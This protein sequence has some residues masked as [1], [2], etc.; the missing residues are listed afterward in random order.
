MKIMFTTTFAALAL[1]ACGTEDLELTSTASA[2]QAAQERVSICHRT[3]NGGSHI[4]TVATPALAAHAKHGDNVVGP[5]TCDDVDNDCNG[6]VDDGDACAVGE[7]EPGEGEASEGETGEGEAGEGEAGEGE[8]GG[9]GPGG[10][11]AGEGPL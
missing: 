2:Q 11:G 6:V 1:V 4:I 8:P 9:G 3:G 5:E 10:G 7:G